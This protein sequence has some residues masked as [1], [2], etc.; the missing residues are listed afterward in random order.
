MRLNLETKNNNYNFFIS[1]IKELE[2]K[3]NESSENARK[4]TK[5]YTHEKIFSEAYRKL[6]E[7]I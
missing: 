4:N 2:E 1:D 5:R 3:L 7:N 6:N